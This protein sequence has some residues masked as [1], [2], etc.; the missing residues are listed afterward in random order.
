MY[1]KNFIITVICLSLSHQSTLAS[2][3]KGIKAARGLILGMLCFADICLAMSM[4]SMQENE[5]SSSKDIF[6]SIFFISNLFFIIDRC[7]PLIKNKCSSSNTESINSLKIKKTLLF[8]LFYS[9]A[10]GI[11]GSMIATE[12]NNE[13][14]I[15]K[16][17]IASTNIISS[18]IFLVNACSKPCY[19]KFY[20]SNTVIHTDSSNAGTGCIIVIDSNENSNR[21]SSNSNN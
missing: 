12:N 7:Y 21:E 14:L 15:P 9:C 6:A 17:V 1:K 20:P 2:N 5:E 3:K 13:P 8:T 10:M 4:F 11:S 16:E 18:I 19:K